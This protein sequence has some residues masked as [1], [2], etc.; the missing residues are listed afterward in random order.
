VKAK[1]V[2]NELD[3]MYDRDDIKALQYVCAVVSFRAAQLVSICES[4]IVDLPSSQRT[5]EFALTSGFPP[6]HPDC[7]PLFPG[8]GYLLE[9]MNKPT[10]TIAVDGSVYKKHPRLKDLLRFYT[11]EYAQERKVCRYR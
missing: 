1:E 11:A 5:R 4:K 3:L 8:I 6:A 2:L 10:A 9:R 7:F